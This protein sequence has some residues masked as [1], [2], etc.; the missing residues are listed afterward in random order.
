MRGRVASGGWT[1]MTKMMVVARFALGSILLL[2]DAA[3]EGS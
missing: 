1:M 2:R 3:K